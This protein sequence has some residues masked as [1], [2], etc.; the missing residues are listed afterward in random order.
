MDNKE[1][2]IG[3]VVTLLS[4]E[5]SPK[6][7]QL[8]NNVI[9]ICTQDYDFVP[10]KELPSVEVSDSGKILRHYFAT[11]K[12]E[13]LSEE[14]LETYRY[15]LIK[16]FRF[17]NIP[18]EEMGTN[19]I[20]YYLADLGTKCSLSYVDDARRVLNTFFDFCV[21]E[22]YIPRNPVSKIKH[23]KQPK[24][25]ERPYSDTEVEM[26]RDACA[27]K[28]DVALI[29]FLFS[30]GCRREEIVKAKI[31]DVDFR[32]RSV[33]IHGKGS[34]DRT[35]YFSA[36]CEKHLR[37]YIE[38]RKGVSEYLFCGSKEPYGQLTNNGLAAIVKRIGARA[39][40]S[41]VH[42]HRF[43]KWF[44]TYM[45]NQGVPLQD[46]KEMMGHSKLDTTNN[47]Y[48]Y[49]NQERIRQNYI[50]HAV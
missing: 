3:N 16:L 4:N 50:N 20:R 12:M 41:N 22:E 31:S 6:Q 7:L 36:R 44:G 48:V 49:T 13:G 1:K 34:K 43:R 25:M 27:D 23:I 39:G 11:K 8:V 9:F 33:L 14:T 2:V 24:T 46:I 37:E 32:N 5:L 45:A 15:H 10:V 26:L 40:V 38:S 19:H 28:R 29:D 17:I 35:V 30:T 47:Y 21:D 42:L 18:I